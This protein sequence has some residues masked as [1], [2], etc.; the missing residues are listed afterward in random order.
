MMT[1]RTTPRRCRIG[2][3]VVSA[4]ALP[5]I[6]FV[7]ADARA[8]QAAVRPNAVKAGQARTAAPAAPAE[9]L[10]SLK[11][12]RSSPSSLPSTRPRS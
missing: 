4:A 6:G 11:M 8:Q 2:G 5:L 1:G 3:F 7:G 9:G 12:M 10:D